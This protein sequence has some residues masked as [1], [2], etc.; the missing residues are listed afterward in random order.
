[1]D[2]RW[3][4]VLLSA[5]AGA[6]QSGR[7]LLVTVD[8]LPMGAGRLHTDAADRREVTEGLLAVLAKHQVQGGRVRRLGQREERR[9][10]RD[11]RALARG[12]ARARQPL[13]RPP[14]LLAHRRGDL[15]RRRRGRARRAPGPARSP[16]TEGALL[17]LPL[18]ARGRN[19]G[20]ARRDA[21]L[22][23]AQRPDQR[24][25]DDRQPGLVVRGD[26]GSR[27]RRGGDAAAR[28]RR[29]R[30][31]PARAAHRDPHPVAARRRAVRARHAPGAAAARQ[32][33]RRGAVGRAVLLGRAGAG[34]ASRPPTRCSPIPRSP[35]RT[36]S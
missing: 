35:R 13:A 12:R 7:P 14:R 1:M 29:R 25:G 23:R 27:P 22:P 8:D 21:R 6:A 4:A 2:V 30:R 17:P 11:P 5:A 19:G 3:S 18:P 31:V 20:E 28:E 26:A 24:P 32:R 10:P 15:H 36:V 9:R 16:P 34:T 33:G